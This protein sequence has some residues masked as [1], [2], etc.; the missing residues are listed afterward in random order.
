MSLGMLV[1][2]PYCYFGKVATDSFLQMSD[3][4][5]EMNWRNLPAKLQKYFIPMIQNMQKPIFYHALYVCILD[6]NT[7]TRVSTINRSQ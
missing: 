4:L 2:F 1:M 7:Y 5:Y 3:Y 6:L